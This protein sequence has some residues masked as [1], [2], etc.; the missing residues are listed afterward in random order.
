MP[1][2]LKSPQ[3]RSYASS[4]GARSHARLSNSTR[5]VEIPNYLHCEPDS[6][7][8]QSI[9]VILIFIREW[10]FILCHIHE[11]HEEFIPFLLETPQIRCSNYIFIIGMEILRVIR[12]SLRNA[13]LILAPLE[14]HD[15]YSRDFPQIAAI[16]V[17]AIVR[18]RGVIRVRHTSI[19]YALI[20][21]SRFRA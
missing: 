2:A 19:I 13:F 20:A 15:F 9:Y 14:F 7:F 21:M 5:S 12:N 4:W 11:F 16:L 10:H 6:E 18:E 8:I 17:A 1:P 3:E